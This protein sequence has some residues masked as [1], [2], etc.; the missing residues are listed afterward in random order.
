MWKVMAECH[1]AQ[2]RTLDEAKLLLTGAPS[3]LEAKRQSCFSAA[4]PL[5]QTDSDTLKLPF[6]P[7]WSSGTLAIFGLC[8]QWSRFLDSICEIPVLDGLDF[9]A[10]GMG[11]LYTQQLREDSRFV[12]VGSKRFGARLSEE[13]GGKM[14]LVKVH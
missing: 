1:Q 8:I 13:S 12:P 11:S 9:F 10:A 2:K 14:D 6:S 4:E 5:L 7:R 3:K